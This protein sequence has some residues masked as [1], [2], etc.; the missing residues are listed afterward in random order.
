M[1][2]RRPISSFVGVLPNSFS[3]SR[4]AGGC[5]PLSDFT[6]QLAQTSL[7]GGTASRFYLLHLPLEMV[8]LFDCPVDLLAELLPLQMHEWNAANRLR[9]LHLGAGQLGYQAFPG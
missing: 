1:S 9:G 8:Q 3:N 6:A 4:D 5:F 7:G 2:I